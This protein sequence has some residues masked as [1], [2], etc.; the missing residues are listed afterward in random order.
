M[1][2]RLC[3]FT[4]LVT[5]FTLCCAC[6]FHSCWFERRRALVADERISIEPQT[7][8]R[9]AVAQYRVTNWAAG[10][11]FHRQ[12][13]RL[14]P[15]YHHHRHLRCLQAPPHGVLPPGDTRFRWGS[16][17]SR[18][19]RCA[20]ELTTPNGPS[21]RKISIRFD[22]RMSRSHPRLA[23]IPLLTRGTCGYCR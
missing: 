13:C 16:R 21:Q 9:T 5:F 17:S 14:L 11:Q 6:A 4:P 7:P 20:W 19:S 10:S 2:L 8:A 3:S 15:L 23:S 22:V 18:I 12:G 1:T